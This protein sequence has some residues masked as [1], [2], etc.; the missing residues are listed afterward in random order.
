MHKIMFVCLGN[1]C[2]SPMAEF[3][4]KDLVERSNLQ[5]DFLIA[6]SA[7]SSEEV[8]NPVHHG[9][10]AVLDR[11][12]IDYK[13]KRARQLTASDYDEYDLFIGMDERN[14]RTMTKIFNG[15]P[16]NKVTLLMDFTKRRREVADPYWTGDF[17]ATYRDVTE[18][19]NALLEYLLKQ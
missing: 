14:C 8:G 19:T 5:N 16:E 1:I 13:G 17:E 9:T 12:G 3:I 15:D 7:T 11:L 2:R 4:M 6:S 10:R 18:G